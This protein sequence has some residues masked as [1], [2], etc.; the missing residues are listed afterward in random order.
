MIKLLKTNNPA[1]YVIM[2]GLM[3]L[4]WGFKFYYMPTPIETTNT[5]SALFFECPETVFCKYMTSILAFALFFAMGLLII[6]INSD[7]QI[8]EG[9]Y[10]TPGVIFV[11]LTG[12]FINVQRMIPEMIASLFLAFAIYRLIAAYKK[13]KA[14]SNCFDAGF[15]MSCS[16]LFINKT[17]FFIPII[18]F[19]LYIIRPFYWRDLVILFFGI[20]TPIILSF[21]IIYLFGDFVAFRQNLASGLFE[22][23]IATKYSVYN[24][25]I[26]SSIVILSIIAIV[27]RF[28]LGVSKKVSARKFLSV[29]VVVTAA[30]L[31]YFAS[32]IATNESIVFLFAPLSLL[33]TNLLVHA[34]KLSGALVF[35]GLIVSVVI[36]QVF[37]IT[38]YLSIF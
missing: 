36:S 2:F 6:Y 31:L 10:Q 1:N 35:Y 13:Y 12:A 37:Q 28:T 18:I 20:L 14:F 22:T 34:K 38:Y 11:L 16:I 4:F 5:I 3:L 27:S 9:G 17:I 29:L 32:P 26:F 21:S 25:I 7:L 15:L 24:Y 8:I 33:L 23:S 30:S 19:S